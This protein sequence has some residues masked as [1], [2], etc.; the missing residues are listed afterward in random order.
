[1]LTQNEYQD[2]LRSVQKLAKIGVTLD[3]T[4]TKPKHKRVGVK[5]NKQYDFEKLAKLIGE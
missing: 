5:F 2:L 3:Y 1:M 4:V